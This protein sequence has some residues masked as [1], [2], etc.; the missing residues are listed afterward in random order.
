MWRD[1]VH[2]FLF[3]AWVA[4]MFALVSVLLSLYLVWQ[5]MR[6]SGRALSRLCRSILAMP[7]S[8]L[9]R[10]SNLISGRE[11]GLVVAGFMR[12][13]KKYWR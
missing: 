3:S 2:R 6:F 11:A 7:G 5:P 13:T 4:V 12:T 9:S 10:L 1:S 8:L